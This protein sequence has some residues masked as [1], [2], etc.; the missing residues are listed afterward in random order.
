MLNQI[1]I[2]FRTRS[3]YGLVRYYPACELANLLVILLNQKSLSSTQLE[4]IRQAG[5]VIEIKK[6]KNS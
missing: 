5:L 6:N 4:I 1:Q 2:A 3:H